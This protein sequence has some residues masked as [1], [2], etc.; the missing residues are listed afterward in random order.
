MGTVAARRTKSL[1]RQRPAPG[2]VNQNNFSFAKHSVH[3]KFNSIQAQT[4]RVTA[5][6]AP[7]G[8]VSSNIR[9]SERRKV[10]RSFPRPSASSIL[11]LDKEGP[12]SVMHNTMTTHGK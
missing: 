12:L 4:S 9:N 5:A 10:K 7:V 11:G 8:D 3:S 2:T 1:V 6:P